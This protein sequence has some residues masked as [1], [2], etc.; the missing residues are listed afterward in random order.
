MKSLIDK[1]K[2]EWSSPRRAIENGKETDFEFICEFNPEVSSEVSNIPD[3]LAVFYRIANGAIL[4]KDVKY[5]QWGLRIAPYTE[6]EDFNKNAKEWRGE[7]LT[8]S[9]LV[10]GEFLGDL[11][12]VITSLSGENYGKITICT[13]MEP[14]EDWYHTNMNFE[15]FLESYIEGDGDKFWES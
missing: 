11:D 3:E 14:R 6:L 2:K 7:D 13:P 4:F 1:L 10:I 8:D 5:G 9:D 15:E 12:L